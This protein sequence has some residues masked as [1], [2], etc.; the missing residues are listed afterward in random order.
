M[1]PSSDPSSRPSRLPSSEPSSIP[2]TQPT[3][4]PTSQPTPLDIID[5]NTLTAP[6]TAEVV[7][8]KVNYYLGAFVAYFIACFIVLVVVD[9][10]RL[11]K[12]EVKKLHDSAYSSSV[13][14]PSSSRGDLP[15]SPAVET[16]THNRIIHN[17]VDK[18][19]R[20]DKMLMHVIEDEKKFVDL[21]GQLVRANRDKSS[22][23]KG[24]AYSA[25]FHAYI[26]QR[27]TFFGCKPLWYPG[28]QVTACSSTWTFQES[29]IEDFVLYICNNHSVLGCV[30]SCDGARVDRTGK[31]LIYIAQNAVAFCASSISG[32]VLNYLGYSD[33]ANMI[34]AILVTAPATFAVGKVMNFLYVCPIGFSVEYEVVHPRVV[35][36]L[37]GLGKL[38]IIPMLVGIGGL[39]VMSAVFSRGYDIYIIVVYFFL[40]VQ[41]YGFFLELVSDS[42]LMFPSQYLGINIDVYV[43]QVVVLEVGRRFVELL[44]HQGLVTEGKDYYFRRR[45]IL[46]IYIDYICLYD[47]AVKKGYVP[48]PS[49]VVGMQVTSVM[50]DGLSIDIASD[51]NEEDHA[52]LYN[53]YSTGANRIDTDKVTMFERAQ[54]LKSNGKNDKMIAGMTRMRQ[55]TP[56]DEDVELYKIYERD[57]I[58]SRDIGMGDDIS[59]NAYDF[60]ENILSFEDWNARRKKFKEGT[61]GSFVTAFQVFED[62]ANSGFFDS[63]SGKKK[64]EEESIP[65]SVSNTVH[66]HD[67]NIKTNPLMKAMN[68]NVV[69]LGETK[70][71]GSVYASDKVERDNA[72]AP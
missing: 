15:S 14:I 67:H 50:H 30:L 65:S 38:A 10:W 18:L 22:I 39:L 2:T 64:L 72:S 51:K 3:S 35:A 45:R 11:G 59:S 53:V 36:F 17:M 31:R 69:M 43:K 49:V 37:R 52:A 48:D 19:K 9:Y 68:K 6:I 27:R 57:S 12:A 4:A 7:S 28:G 70:S 46:F 61:R 62:L 66:L 47:E 32:S 60:T 8:T 26:Y 41:L 58:A 33:R 16:S 21:S 42:L 5:L 71:L 56:L 54:V 40:N 63:N 24:S 55:A 23:V 29:A 44:H 13:F 34:F 25:T 1:R 20:W